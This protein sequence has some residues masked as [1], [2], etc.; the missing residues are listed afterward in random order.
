[1]K[2]KPVHRAIRLDDALNELMEAEYII[3]QLKRKEAVQAFTAGRKRQ[4]Q[5]VHSLLRELI[6]DLEQDNAQEQSAS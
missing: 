4:F 6:H 1:M 3:A 5:I 2:K